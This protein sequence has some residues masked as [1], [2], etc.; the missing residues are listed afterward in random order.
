VYVTSEA[1]DAAQVAD[2]RFG[3]LVRYRYRLFLK[4]AVLDAFPPYRTLR[5]ALGS[6][7]GAHVVE[8]IL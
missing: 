6:S 2:A 1:S 8:E 3:V 7:E 4:G 5:D